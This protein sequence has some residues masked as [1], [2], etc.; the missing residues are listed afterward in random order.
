MHHDKAPI[1]DVHLE[2]F[3]QQV[4]QAS[5]QIPI[6]VDFWAEWCSPCLA[7]A[8]VLERV[9][10]GY[11]GRVRLAKLEVDE[12]ENM[13]LAGRYRV[14]GFPTVVLFIK[15][16]EVARFVSARPRHWIEEFLDQHL[17]ELR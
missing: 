5:H 9:M 8:P 10:A 15:G 13:K 4:I 7:L 11:A 1:S 2:Q 14:R 17:P 3:E 6:M 12:G 16:E